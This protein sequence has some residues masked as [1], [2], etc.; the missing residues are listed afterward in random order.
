MDMRV[1]LLGGPIVPW[2]GA[3]DDLIIGELT[4]FGGEEPLES[5]DPLDVMRVIERILLRE[6]VR[7]GLATVLMYI[8]DAD[9]FDLS[10]T[11]LGDIELGDWENR[12]RWTPIWQWWP[13][14]ALGANQVADEPDFAEDESEERSVSVTAW[15]DPLAYAPSS[16]A[17]AA[18]LVTNVTTLRTPDQVGAADVLLALMAAHPDT[19]SQYVEPFVHD[20]WEPLRL[21]ARRATS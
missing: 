17:A 2:E 15:S 10:I 5:Y 6:L 19:P 12:C 1:A 7:D 18:W 8:N 9:A 13:E 16:F 14:F 4:Y 3:V 11:V 21:L 20:P